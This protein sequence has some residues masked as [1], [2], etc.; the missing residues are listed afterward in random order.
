MDRDRL[1][2]VLREAWSK[3]ALGRN[4]YGGIIEHVPSWDQMTE[5][6][7]EVDRKAAE[8][9]VAE[10]ANYVIKKSLLS[11]LTWINNG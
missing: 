4:L 11:V 1:G 8:A 10:Y 7:K 5:E 6:E 2:R 3:A 9:V